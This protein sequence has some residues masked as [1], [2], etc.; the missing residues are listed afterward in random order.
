MNLFHKLNLIKHIFGKIRNILDFSRIIAVILFVLEQMFE[1]RSE[2]SAQI[3]EFPMNRVRPAAKQTGPV[4]N[5]SQPQAK[6][7]MS[8]NLSWPLALVRAFLAWVLIAAIALALIVGVGKQIES[9]QASVLTPSNT[10]I[11]EFKYVTIG[12]GDT[13]WALAERFAPDQDPRD[14]IADIVSLNGLQDSLVD[15]GMRLALPAN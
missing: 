1:E 7:D 6:T 8:L 10:Q 12:S 15:V 4:S 11:A 13:L 14:F 9:A 5:Y 3:I 2:M